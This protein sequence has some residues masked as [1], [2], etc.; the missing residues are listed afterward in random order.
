MPIGFVNA[1]NT[2]ASALQAW[3][4]KQEELQGNVCAICGKAEIGASPSK[5]GGVK[6]LSIDHD[7]TTG[8]LRALLCTRCNSMLG[9]AYDSP[10]LLI[11][12]AKY[13]IAHTSGGNHKS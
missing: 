13:L 8:K 6:R 10:E 7:H 3:K 11:A 2:R 12:A 1:T 5:Y 4:A 9:M